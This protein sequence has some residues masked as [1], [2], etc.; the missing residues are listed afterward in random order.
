MKRHCCD[1]DAGCY[2]PDCD[3]DE[4]CDCTCGCV[5]CDNAPESDEAP[6]IRGASQEKP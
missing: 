4:D 2:A 3:Y 5:R 6:E 1:D